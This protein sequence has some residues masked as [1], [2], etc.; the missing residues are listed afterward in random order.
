MQD[1]PNYQP[2]LWSII[3]PV[4]RKLLLVGIIFYALG[5][6]VEII[7]GPASPGVV[8]MSFGVGE[9]VIMSMV[10]IFEGTSSRTKVKLTYLTGFLLLFAGTFMSALQPYFSAEYNQLSFLGLSPFV[11]GSSLLAAQFCASRQAGSRRVGAAGL[12]LV[13][14]GIPIAY[15]YGFVPGMNAYLYLALLPLI[16]GITVIAIP[17]LGRKFRKMDVSLKQ[18]TVY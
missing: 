4:F 13:I 16:F 1:S 12:I 2:T 15:F 8:P 5:A 6:A 9:I 17:V 14:V 3:R 18:N 11:I 7:F 10:H